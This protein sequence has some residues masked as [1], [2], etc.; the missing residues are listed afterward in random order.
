M[1]SNSLEFAQRLEDPVRRIANLD[2]LRGLATTFEEDCLARRAAAT[3]AGL[4]TFLGRDVSD[5]GPQPASPDRDGV[6][7][8]TYHRAKG[9]EWPVVILLDLQSEA[10]DRAFGLATEPAPEGFDVWRPLEGRWLRYWPWPYGQQSK[11]V[12]LD[13]KASASPEGGHARKRDHSEMRRLLY[14]G[15]TRARDYLIMAPKNGAGATGWLD[16][17]FDHESG[18]S[19]QL[20][21]EP[22]E[23]SIELG[24]DAHPVSVQVLAGASG[25]T[26]TAGSAAIYAPP[27][28]AE[29]PTSQ[30]YRLRPSEAGK[31]SDLQ[32]AE[33]IQ[34][35]ER[36]P[37][38]GSPDMA[39][40]GDA[41]H[42]F[43][44]ADDPDAETPRRLAL[45]SRLLVAWQVTALSPDACLV[46]ADRLKAFV[47]ERYPGAVRRHEWP[48]SGML[49][50][51]R[52]RG[53]IDLLLELP[54]RLTIIDHKSFPGHPETW[55][56][57]AL[58]A[59]A[60]LETYAAIARTASGLETDVWVH[61]PIVGQFSRLERGS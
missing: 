48:V 21:K 61:M 39:M 38:S 52:V 22:G 24:D 13:A 47:D 31:R 8:L 3:A 43:L 57:R 6:Q 50:S 33:T 12:F 16:S 4:V 41:L 29:K 19:L 40:L 34:L 46:A 51:Q 20:P 11:D 49:G 54:E 15:M 5:G 53:Q 1:K 42:R 44:A 37:L 27:A 55:H 9:L 59:G 7:V 60:Q 58:L 36:L 28:R 17:L 30:A 14:V 10:R 23:Q 18:S 26:A 45:A 35:G 2:A 56:N 32:V 25:T